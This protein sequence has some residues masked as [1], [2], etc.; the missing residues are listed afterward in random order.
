MDDHGIRIGKI[1]KELGIST[2]TINFYVAQGILPAPR[3]LSRTRAA[4]D[5]RHVRILKLIRRM[6]RAGYS[7]AY[8]KGIFEVVG[9]DDDGLGKIEQIGYLQPLPPAPMDP[10]QRPIEH[11][12][13]LDRAAFLQRFDLSA[14]LLDSLEQLGLV[15]PIQGRYDARDLWAVRAARVLFDEGVRVES[16]RFV[17]R[18][19]PILREVVPLVQLIAMRRA[20]ALRARKLRFTDIIQPFASLLGYLFNRVADLET[21]GWRGSLFLSTPEAA[22]ETRAGNGKGRKKNKKKERNPRR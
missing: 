17:E 14:P 1:A 20:D 11:F 4:Y 3:K 22:P 5:A 13:P 9:T 10:D 18:L 2:A 19:R 16:L 21:P 12:E 7:L 8:I 15:L 6:Q